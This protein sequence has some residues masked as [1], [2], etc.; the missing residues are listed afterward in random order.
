MMENNKN[1]AIEVEDLTVAYH[2]N[3]VLWDID[4]EVE[5]GLMSAII[6]PNGAGKST[7]LKAL[8]HLVPISSGTI[9][10]FGQPLQHMRRKVAYVPQRNE[11]DWDFPTTVL[12]VV[13]M[14][15]YGSLGWFVPPGKK[16]KLLAIQALEKVGMESFA[17][18]Q[19]RE[20]SGGQQQRTFIARTLV[21]DAE[22]YLMDEPF[23]GVD[24]A[25][26]A[27][28]IEVLR[29]LRSKGKTLIIVHHDLQTVKEYFDHII[30]LNVH[31]IAS[32]PVKDV[33][34]AYNLQK[35]YKGKFNALKGGIDGF[36]L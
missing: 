11:V 23:A 10:F 33:F 31:T 26:E 35:A 8:L 36:T 30:L 29:E 3:P 2:H 4:T 14:G 20:L 13:M 19:I 6:G 9:K 17:H 25:T 22:I 32:G 24:A 34:T 5:K 21:Q 27:S 7:L 15:S 12:D 28:I 16:E 18:R 1:Y